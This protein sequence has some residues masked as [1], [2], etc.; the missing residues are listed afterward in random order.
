MSNQNIKRRKWWIYL[1]GFSVF[2]HFLFLGHFLTSN[3][4]LGQPRMNE[5]MN[6]EQ[7]GILPTQQPGPF[8]LIMGLDRKWLCN[9]LNSGE[10]W[11]RHCR[12]VS[13]EQFVIKQTSL[14][15]FSWPYFLSSA[16]LQV[17]RTN[18]SNERKQGRTPQIMDAER[19]VILR[20]L[21]ECCTRPL[22]HMKTDTVWHSGILQVVNL[23]RDMG[24]VS[25]TSVFNSLEYFFPM[26]PRDIVLTQFRHLHLTF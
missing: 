1:A 24:F 20:P 21:G 14:R 11:G 22:T 16:Y 2:L 7:K 18:R 12:A 3:H 4:S 9:P 26:P 13:I 6:D 23:Y 17:I 25:H 8:I 19:H 15:T 5:W 10:W